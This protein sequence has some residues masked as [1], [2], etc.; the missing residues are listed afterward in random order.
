MRRTA[1]LMKDRLRRKG[2]DSASS[3]R[4]KYDVVRKEIAISP[5]FCNQ[6]CLIYSHNFWGEGPISI[7]DLHVESG[8]S[9]FFDPSGEDELNPK[10]LFLV[11]DAETALRIRFQESCLASPLDRKQLKTREL[12]FR[13]PPL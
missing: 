13:K 9:T 11:T 10:L 7:G 12:L 3:S 2:D 1:L 6:L 5:I 8:E 4:Q